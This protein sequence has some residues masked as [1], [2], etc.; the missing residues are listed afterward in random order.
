VVLTW[1]P[2]WTVDLDAPEITLVGVLVQ[3]RLLL[4]L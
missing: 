1:Q 2:S 4:G 3:R